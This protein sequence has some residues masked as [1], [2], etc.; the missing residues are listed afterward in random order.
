MR[1]ATFEEASEAVAA[2]EAAEAAAEAAGVAAEESDS[3]EDD[4]R[5]LA[6]DSE[7]SERSPFLRCP[8]IRDLLYL[9]HATLSQCSCKTIT[10]A[11]RQF[12]CSLSLDAHF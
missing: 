1:H 10:L 4:A 8:V 7:D 11:K 5:K 3:D 2:I 6:S 12:M 9:G